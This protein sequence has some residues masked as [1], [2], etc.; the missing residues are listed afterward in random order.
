M[1]VLISFKLQ[2][3]LKVK[4]HGIVPGKQNRPKLKKK[5]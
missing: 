3:F 2:K 1:N 4:T 5:S